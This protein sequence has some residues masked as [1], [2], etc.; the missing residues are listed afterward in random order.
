MREKV[1]RKLA[2]IIAAALTA[3]L[4][5]MPAAG[6]MKIGESIKLETDP[7]KTAE[8][9]K[10]IDAKPQMT[11]PME[12]LTRG[13]VAFKSGKTVMITW[14]WLGTE[15]ANTTYNVYRN[16]EK[17]TTTPTPKTMYYDAS[18]EAG[19]TY[20]IAAVTDGK[21]GEKS[22]PVSVWEDNSLTIPIQKPDGDTVEGEAYTYTPGDASVGDLDGDGEYEIVLKWDPSNAKDAAS[23]GFTGK[24][25]I[26]AYEMDGTRLWRIDMG[27]N[28]RAGAHDTQFMVYDYDGDGKAEVAMRTADGTVAGDGTVIGD[29]KKNWAV[30]NDGKNLQGPLYMTV[31]EGATGKVLDTTDYDPQTGDLAVWG[32]TY[33]NRSERYLATVGYVDGATPSVIFG[34]GYYSGDGG[35]GRTV[36]A[37]F[38]FKDGKIVKDWT[39][40]TEKEGNG[41]YIAQGNHSMIAADVDFDGYDEVIY[42]ALVVDHDGKALYSTGL[43]HGD[44]QHTS[45]L[46]PNRPGLETFSVHEHK[47]AKYSVEMRD[48]RTGEFILGIPCLNS[49]IGRGVSDDI[50]PDHYG[51]ESWAAGNMFDSEGTVI[52]EGQSVP[53]NFL[54]YWDGDL[55]REVQDNINIGKWNPKKNKSDVIFTASGCTAVNGTKS[56]PSLTADLFGDWREEA[57]YPTKDGTAL[58][59]FTTDIPTGYK[60]PTLMHN[61]LYRQYIATQNVTY[62]QPAHLSYYLG[63]D[64]EKV[65]VPEITV[66]GTANPDLDKKSWNIRDINQSDG[67][68]LV[69]GQPKA[70]VEGQIVRV[71]NGSDKTVPYIAEGDR[72]LVPIRFI[73]EAFGADVDWNDDTRQVTITR[74]DTTIVM[75]IDEAAYTVNGQ[76]KTLEAPATIKNDRTFVPIRHITEMFGKT[77]AY[78]DD[79]QLIAITDDLEEIGG[80]RAKMIY[81]S[82]MEAEIPDPVEER[83]IAAL[84]KLYENQADVYAV[85]ASGNDGN[86]ETNAVDGDMT[87]RWSAY[88]ANTLTLDLK[89]ETEITGVA[90]AM[91]KGAERIYPFTIEVSTDGKTWTT[92]LEKT[93]NSGTTEEAEVYNFKKSVKAR[94]VRYSGDGATDPDKNYCHISEMVVLKK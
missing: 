71:D 17:L 74:K 8:T 11:R 90:I 30:L 1:K 72:T 91:W 81:Q 67:V 69:I 61:S 2:A 31:F 65:P 76:K 66:D 68:V 46:I 47:D 78:F 82:I 83:P 15:S 44:A 36:I 28:I 51:A 37:S 22:E 41:G 93:E 87:T 59:I 27:P 14:R 7:Q 50:D 21:E 49:D 5:F 9:Q 54:I 34:R 92:A 39:F 56:T 6:A 12:N 58:K 73:S 33:G 32:D 20:Q 45:D 75:T 89:D 16:G 53:E 43:G 42:G 77:V 4:A 85:E 84:E 64:T 23:T 18:P 26:D 10:L 62:N 35:K 25:I 88:G 63:F 86:V 19:A 38:H 55:G 80:E 40:D 70:A 48:A 57:V 29:A 13:V 94:Y 60:V 3:Q 24:C 79:M 52:A